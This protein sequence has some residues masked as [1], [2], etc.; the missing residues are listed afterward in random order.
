[1]GDNLKK[2]R[3]TYYE[4]GRLQPSDYDPLPSWE[5]L[6]IQLREAFIHVWHEGHSQGARES[7]LQK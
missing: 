3:A 7:K 5:S 1:M 6:P 2:I 4:A